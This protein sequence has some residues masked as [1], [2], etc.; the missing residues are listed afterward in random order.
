MLIS[1]EGIDY[2]GKS[3]QIKLLRKKLSDKGYKVSLFRDPGGNNIS[4]SIR[5]ILLDN[6]NE[7]MHY[8]TEVLLYEAAR[9]QMVE[10]SIVPLL[11]RNEVVLLDRFYDSTTAYQGYG[12]GIRLMAINTLNEFARGEVIP[13]ITFFIDISLETFAGRMNRSRMGQDR[14]ESS[15]MDFFAKVREGYLRIAEQEPRRIMVIDGNR[16]IEKIEN[17]IWESVVKKFSLK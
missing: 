11:K 17:E 6:S 5:K 2:S 14:L 7:L 12:R 8:R 15:G 9:A 1:F 16:E 3:T 10:E 13:D 4:E